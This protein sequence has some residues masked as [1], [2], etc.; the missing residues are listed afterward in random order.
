MSSAAVCVDLRVDVGAVLRPQ[1]QVELAGLHLV[2]QRV[3]CPRRGCRARPP[4]ARTRRARCPGTLPCTAP[5]RSVP[6][7]AWVSSGIEQA[8][9]EHGR[10]DGQR[11]AP[12]DR[13]RSRRAAS[14]IRASSTPTATTAPVSSGR[15]AAARRTR[16]AG[17]SAWENASRPHGKPPNGQAAAQLLG[18]DEEDREDDDLQADAAPD[19]VARGA[20][21]STRRRRA[22]STS[23]SRVL[24]R[25]PRHQPDGVVG[26]GDQREEEREPPDEADEGVPARAVATQGQV[27]EGD[28][29]EGR[30]PPAGRREREAGEHATRDGEDESP[31][32][33]GFT[34][35]HHRRVRQ[36]AEAVLAPGVRPTGPRVLRTG[37]RAGARTVVY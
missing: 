25:E 2:E 1:H 20:P 30:A 10:D 17:E 3:A 23:A 18:R 29:D 34:G 7:C 35:G 9:D 4:A 37:R 21:R 8:D 22:R 31:P 12:A 24:Q 19:R 5:T 13:A 28:A 16:R 6:V 33:G 26:P 15:P 11:D 32:A 36:P 27:Q 14:R